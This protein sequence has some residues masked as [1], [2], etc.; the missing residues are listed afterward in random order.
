MWIYC[1]LQHLT[2]NV[3]LIKSNLEWKMILHKLDL[4]TE[5]LHVNPM[6]AWFLSL[7]MYNFRCRTTYLGEDAERTDIVRSWHKSNQ[8][9]LL[10]LGRLTYLNLF[11]HIIKWLSNF[12]LGMAKDQAE[13][14]QVLFDFRHNMVLCRRVVPV[15]WQSC[16]W[17]KKEW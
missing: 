16:K 8:N 7:T 4:K 6:Y 14:N 17:R 15:F 10:R 1:N 5:K 2:I 3:Y 11:W 9:K 12:Y 13:S